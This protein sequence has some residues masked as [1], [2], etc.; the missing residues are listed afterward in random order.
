ML[1]KKKNSFKIIKS[2]LFESIKNLVLYLFCFQV[3]IFLAVFFWYQFSPIKKIHTPEKI[4]NLISS[5]IFKTTGIEAKRSTNYV[6][7]YLKSIYYN[8]VPPK[9]PKLYLNL[10][11][12][13]VIA[14]EF[15]RQNR[16]NFENL[17]KEDRSLVEKYVSGTLLYEKSEYPVK[18][19]VKGDREIHFAEPNFTSYKID[20]TSEDRFNGLEEFSI[21]KPIARNYIYEYIFQ[22]LSKES[23]IISL[24]YLVVNFF[25]NGIDRGIFVIEEGFS[26]ELLEKNGQRNGPIFGINDRQGRNFPEIIFE[27]YSELDWYINDPDKIKSGYSILNSLKENKNYYENFINWDEWA[28]YFAVSDLLEA[29]HGVLPRSAR[30]YYNPIIGKI[31]PISFDGHKGTGDFSN[32]IILDFLNKRSSCSWICD[33]RDWFLKFFLKDESNLR[34]EFIE[35]YL[36]HLDLITE[37]SYIDNF[38]NKYQ[39]EI[40]LY[41]KAFYKDFSKVDKIFWKGIAPYIYDDKYLYK[42]AKFIKNKINNINFDEFIF[43]KNEDKLIIKGFLNSTPVKIIPDCGKGEDLKKVYWVYKNSTINWNKNCEKIVISDFNNISKKIN[44]YNNPKLNINY[45]PIDLASFKSFEDTIKNIKKDKLIIPVEENIKIKEN[46]LLNKNLVLKLKKNQNIYLSN[47]ASLVVF[48]DLQI[49]GNKNNKSKIEGLKPEYGSL[50][51]KGN[52]NNISNTIFKNLK[53]PNLKG[54]SLY[55]A[56]NFINSENY[57]RN[58]IFE[59]SH[60]EDFVNFINSKTELENIELMDTTSDAID[61]DAGKLNFINLKCK[62]IGNDCLDFS[63]SEISGKNF[64]SERVQDKSI[65]VGEKSKVEIK[66]LNLDNSEIAIAVKDS[67]KANVSNIKINNST[68]PFAVFVKKSEYGPASLKVN[69]LILNNSNDVFLVDKISTLEIDGKRILGNL[70]G[71]NIE[72]MMYG[73]LYGKQTNR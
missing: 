56:V 5:V 8:L 46:T 35:K 23:K 51:L 72:G 42:R 45:F 50:I 7:S 20:I 70:E 69:D 22:K 44:L 59:K 10:N 58:S 6:N 41:N 53:A 43:S 61:V 24:D 38:L 60:S 73:N 11:Q 15:Q 32:F 31:D 9:I 55:G 30:F 40:K 68:V 54:F 63:N 67:S 29:Y 64:F 25:V 26:K 3:I 27:A 37:E 34:N 62:N 12:K 4:I 47:G 48:G 52:T 66:N 19:R 14:L 71:E 36:E 1:I 2:K 16:A 57:I 18:L 13:S 28:K 49:E 33:E 21:Q 39:T 17:D 65:S